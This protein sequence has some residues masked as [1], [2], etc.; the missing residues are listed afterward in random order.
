MSDKL[1][2]QEIFKELQD[3]AQDVI[4]VLEEDAN[5]ENCPH[6]LM[7]LEADEKTL[8][9]DH[10]GLLTVKLTKKCAACE[11][12]LAEEYAKYAYIGPD[13]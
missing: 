10:E 12:P 13:N 7:T 1:D 9:L 4:T 6:R 11:E 2:E 3:A 5:A 8:Q